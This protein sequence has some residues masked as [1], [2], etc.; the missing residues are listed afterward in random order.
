MAEAATTPLETTDARRAA[1]TSFSDYERKRRRKLRLRRLWRGAVGVAVMLVLWDL[2]SRLYGLELILPRPLVVLQRTV[3]ML[4][5]DTGRWLYGPNV[6]MHL[7]QS[8]SRAMIGFAIAA[9]AGIPLGLWLGRSQTA[10]EFIQPVITSLYPI[11]GIAWIPLAILWFGLS[12]KAVVFVV[13]LAAFFPLYYAA[14]AGAR[15]ISPVLLDA[16]RCFGAN[17]LSLFYRV[18]L[19]AT[20][21]FLT[22]GLRIALGGAWRMVVAGEIL[23]AQSGIGYMLMEARFQFRAV[24]LMTAMI[25]VSIVG[26]LTELFIVRVI[27]KRTTEKWE[28]RT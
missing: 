5:L 20:V 10:R 27:E 24:D 18:I 19:P 23:A 4:T 25:L 28:V 14:E 3:A 26:Y 21:P 2:L 15:Q 6:Y 17:G 9:A 7:A 11:P 12:E 16:G 8:F 22:T 13:V 1:P